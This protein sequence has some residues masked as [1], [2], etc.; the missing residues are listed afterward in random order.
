MPEKPVIPSLGN[1]AEEVFDRF[2]EYEKKGYLPV[3]RLCGDVPG[4]FF[5]TRD[6]WAKQHFDGISYEPIPRKH[7]HHYDHAVFEAIRRGFATILVRMCGEMVEVHR[8]TGRPI[9]QP[10]PNADAA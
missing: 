6:G 4:T 1:T 7:Q 5:L 10:R 3:I 9:G 8:A 2:F